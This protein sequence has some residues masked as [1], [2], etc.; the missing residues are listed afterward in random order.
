MANHYSSG[1]WMD[2]CDDP[3]AGEAEAYR[4]FTELKAVATTRNVLLPVGTDYSRRTS[5]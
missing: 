5:G 3:G 2:A 1:W 4:L